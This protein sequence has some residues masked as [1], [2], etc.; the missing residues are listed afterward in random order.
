[1]M[2]RDKCRRRMVAQLGRHNDLWAFPQEKERKK[3]PVEDDGI[4]TLQA[5]VLLWIFATFFFK[6][7]AI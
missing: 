5:G 4:D 7:C 1:M 2:V 6:R 3:C